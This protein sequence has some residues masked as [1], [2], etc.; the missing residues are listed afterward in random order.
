VVFAL[1]FATGVIEAASFL[2]FEVFTAIMTGN[3]IFLGLGLAGQTETPVLRAPVAVLAF[4]LG[5]VL[6]GRLQRR[7]P[8]SARCPRSS[9][10]LL[11]AAAVAV[12]TGGGLSTIA[13][14]SELGLGALTALLAVAMGL[15]VAVVRR[16]AVADM[17]TVVVTITLASWAADSRAGRGERERALRRLTAIAVMVL[18]AVIGALLVTRS[19][20]SAFVVA[21][22]VML[23]AAVMT[24][25]ASDGAGREAVARLVE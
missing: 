15:Q 7:L 3:V 17:S 25:R 16:L 12:I 5:A 8:R 2:A 19:P 20:G 22:L 18:G 14:T 9:G 13:S 1:T 6:V 23:A 24:L 10:W 21:G 4:A 11:I